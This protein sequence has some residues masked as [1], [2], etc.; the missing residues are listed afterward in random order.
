V[1]DLGEGGVAA[2]GNHG[3]Q[4]CFSRKAKVASLKASLRSPATMWSA[5]AMSANSACGTELQEVVDAFLGEHVGEAAADQQ[6]RDLQAAGGVAQALGVA[7]AAALAEHP[8]VPVPEVA[9]V[10]QAQ[11]LQ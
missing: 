4:R 5:P 8:R 10:P 9:A 2:P 7:R 11:V 6:G 3:I 1:W